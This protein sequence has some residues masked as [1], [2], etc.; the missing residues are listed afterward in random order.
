MLKG[1]RKH[2]DEK[3]Y[4]IQNIPGNTYNEAFTRASNQEKTLFNYDHH[5]RSKILG[6]K[7]SH[8]LYRA[9]SCDVFIPDIYVPTFVITAKDDPITKYK[10]VPIDD[11]KRNSNILLAVYEKGGHC[12]FF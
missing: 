9:T 10:C 3:K 1:I 11:L 2:F 8:S 4:L 6:F 5:V 7:G 12:D